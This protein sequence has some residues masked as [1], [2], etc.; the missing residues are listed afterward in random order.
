MSHTD[1]PEIHKTDRKKPFSLREWLFSHDLDKR[2]F[3]YGLVFGLPGLALIFIYP[4]VSEYIG[5][6]KCRFL[7]VTGFYCPGCGCTRA[8]RS[9]LHGHFLLSFLYNPAVLY[10]VVLWLLY[11]GSHI[12]ELLHVPHIRGM[13]FRY[14][15]IYA[16][17]VILLGNWIIKNIIMYFLNY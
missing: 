1:N 7:A 11:E 8:V 13:K 4:S 5:P 2:M 9:I 6:E 17:I 15:Y 10:G 3:I 12:L 14:G 16:G